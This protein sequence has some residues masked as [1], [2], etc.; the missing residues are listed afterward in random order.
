LQQAAGYLIGV[1]PKS[2]AQAGHPCS[3]L[4]SILVLANI[5]F[6]ILLIN[7]KKKRRLTKELERYWQLCAMG[8]SR[9]QTVGW[10]L[11]NRKVKL[12]P[13]FGA[14]FTWMDL[15]WSSSRVD[16]GDR[17]DLLF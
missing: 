11:G 15:L 3:K 7:C 16:R 6:I 4:Q 1:A 14:T 5:F 10:C 12:V 17:A 8:H 2:Q 9:G 13:F